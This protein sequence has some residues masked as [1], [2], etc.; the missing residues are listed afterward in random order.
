MEYHLSLFHKY[1]NKFQE[2]SDLDKV[3]WSVLEYK[4][5]IQIQVYSDLFTRKAVWSMKETLS[6]SFV[7]FSCSD[8]IGKDTVVPVNII[9][10]ANK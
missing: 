1:A 6:Y 2:N 9:Q 7:C 5:E 3:T 4:A 10:M 8:L